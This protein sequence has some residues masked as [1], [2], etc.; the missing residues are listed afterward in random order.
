MQPPPTCAINKSRAH[1]DVGDILLS[2]LASYL[3]WFSLA[4]GASEESTIRYWEQPN[5]QPRVWER[6]VFKDE[7]NKPFGVYLRGELDPKKNKVRPSLIEHIFEQ[8]RLVVTTLYFPR[9]K[10]QASK[11]LFNA[12]LQNQFGHRPPPPSAI[13]ETRGRVTTYYVVGAQTWKWVT[14][15]GKLI[16]RVSS[17]T[18][19]PTALAEAIALG[20]KTKADPRA[21]SSVTE[22]YAN[23]HRRLLKGEKTL[24][25]L[26]QLHGEKALP[27]LMRRD[28]SLVIAMLLAADFSAS[29][30][31]PSDPKCNEKLLDE[32]LTYAPSLKIDIEKLRGKCVR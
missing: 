5:P 16:A 1:F 29:M 3:I 7:L 12:W 22:R 11:R 30:N 19:V 17:N 9:L 23:L 32:A 24:L 21:V 2:E 10:A 26:K 20:F 8:D 13:H 6:A 14:D 28:V 25:A 18:R 4:L 27:P 15:D 31:L